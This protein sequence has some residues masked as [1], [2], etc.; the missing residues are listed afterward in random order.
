MRGYRLLLFVLATCA[1]VF[2]IAKARTH[3]FVPVYLNGRLFHMPVEK[4][5]S[6]APMWARVFPRRY[7]GQNGLIIVFGAEELQSKIPS[8]IKQIGNY[9]T[10]SVVSV[11]ALTVDQAERLRDPNYPLYRDACKWEGKYNEQQV[12]YDDASGVYKVTNPKYNFYWSALRIRPDPE[13]AMPGNV[14]DFWVAHCRVTESPNA[15]RAVLT[16][17]HS[18][19]VYKNDIYFDFRINGEN[20]VHYEAMR[21]FILEQLSSWEENK[22]SSEL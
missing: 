4:V 22:K 10:D 3:E 14:N 12:E 15:S 11:A 1:M 19:G 5:I 9:K 21:E 16:I 18:G 7:S 20:L 6:D 2:A 8:Y 13:A 17:C